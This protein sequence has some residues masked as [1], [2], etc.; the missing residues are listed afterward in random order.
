MKYTLSLSCSSW[1]HDPK[2]HHKPE[3]LEQRHLQTPGF[4]DVIIRERFGV[5]CRFL[6]FSD[7]AVN[8]FTQ[9]ILNYYQVHI[10]KYFK[11]ILHTKAVLSSG[12]DSSNTLL[13]LSFP[14]RKYSQKPS[15]CPS[16]SAPKSSVTFYKRSRS[17]TLKHKINSRPSVTETGCISM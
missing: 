17:F 14:E 12:W 5:I 3:N 16:C 4:S 2:T 6:L 7:N 1:L 15:M 13:A 9:A 10:L 11:P 8:Q